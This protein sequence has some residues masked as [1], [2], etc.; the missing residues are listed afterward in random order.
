MLGYNFKLEILCENNFVNFRVCLFSIFGNF[1]YVIFMFN[2]YLCNN[3]W[4]YVVVI[5]N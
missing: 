5:V 4:F 1:I 2:L 3:G